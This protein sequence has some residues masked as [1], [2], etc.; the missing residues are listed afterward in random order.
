M[1]TFYLREESVHRLMMIKFF[2]LFEFERELNLIDI[3]LLYFNITVHF[4][5]EIK[6]IIIVTPKCLFSP[7]FRKEKVEKV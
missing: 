4:V 2:Q 6:I 7:P 3:E 1:Y 5:A